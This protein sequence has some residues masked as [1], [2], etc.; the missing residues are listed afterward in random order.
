MYNFRI[1]DLNM[2]QLREQ[3]MEMFRS[4]VNRFKINVSFGF[5]LRN[6]ENG[7]LRYYHSS[8][9]LG[10]MLE[11]PHQIS[12]AEDFEAFLEA[13]IEEDIL[14]WARKQRP[15]TKWTVVL[16]T[17]ATFYINH[18]HDHPIGCV[19]TELPHYIKNNKAVIGLVKD[20]HGKV[21]YQDNMCFFRALAIHQGVPWDNN[22]QITNAVKHLLSL[23]TKEDPSTFEGIQLQDLPDMELKFELNIMVFELKKTEDENVVVQI[24]QRSHR[25]YTDTMYLNLYENH[26]SLITNLEQYCRV[27]QCRVCGKLWKTVW[28]MNR[29][30]RTCN[31]VTK[32]KFVGGSYQ[33]EPTVFELL[34]D[35]GIM[36]P[37]EDRYYPYRITYDFE[38]Y[39]LKENLPASSEKLTWEAKHE[40]LSVSICSNVPGFMD[41]KCIITVGSA[42]DLV[43]EMVNYLHNIQTTAQ[44]CVQEA[45]QTYYN[46]LVELLQQKQQLEENKGDTDDDDVIMDEIEDKEKKSHPLYTVKFKYEQWM[47]QIPVIGFNSGKYDINMVK[48]HLVKVLMKMDAI[49]FV[50]KKSNSFMCLQ[51][52]QLNFVDIR[53]YL[54]PGFD[55]ATYLKAYKCSVMK[56]F[57]PYEWMN[58][59]DKLNAETLPRHADF[60]STLKNKNI[61]AEDYAYCQKIW[62]EEHMTTMKDYLIWYNNRDVVPFLEALEKQFN[63]YKQLG[64]D[65]FKDGISVPGLT[66]KYL[67]KTS[68][69]TFCLYDKKNS[70]LHDLVSRKHGR[71]T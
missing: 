37:E 39:F 10:R 9:N 23:I 41:P 36:V 47:M 54:A 51:T 58:N 1:E 17:N 60:F 16:V 2:N 43:M 67:F 31:Q 22:L 56:G 32:K 40:P 70:D 27:A 49:K 57:F 35:E 20:K 24:V 21:L 18:L 14:E 55:Y 66:L 46:D 7:E 33:P 12:N 5:I 25:R 61:T 28:Q 29:H 15:N 26:F 4:Q 45:H 44:A 68:S 63:F 3:L 64:V 6:I 69:S 11:A 19:N 59:L 71:R 42:E 8:H 30:E 38:S 52:E 62:K 34:E 50:V 65:M 48:P 13:V 53:N